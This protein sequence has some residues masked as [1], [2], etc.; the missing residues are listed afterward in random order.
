METGQRTRIEPKL[1]SGDIAEELQGILVR[2]RAGDISE[3]QAKLEQA[4]LQ[5]TLKAIEQTEL[6]AKLEQ[7][8]PVIQSR[9]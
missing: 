2:F 9:R 5:S 3:P 6:A 1:N 8:E 7:L 4:V